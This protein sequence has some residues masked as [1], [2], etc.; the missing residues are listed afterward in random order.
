M[1]ADEENSVLAEVRN[2]LAEANVPSVVADGY[3]VR[4][5]TLAQRV[6]YLRRERDRAREDLARHKAELARLVLATAPTTKTTP[7]PIN[8]APPVGEH[9]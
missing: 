6:D 2:A 3:N 7:E 5:L 8:V 4:G 9:P 1:S